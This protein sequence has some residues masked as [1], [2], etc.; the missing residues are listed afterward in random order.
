MDSNYQKMIK[1]GK[2]Y[3]RLLEFLPDGKT[4]QVRS[5]S[6]VSKRTRKSKFEEFRFEL[7]T[8]SSR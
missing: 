4:V 3:M 1:G 5:Y 7:K 6:P 8:A 2:G